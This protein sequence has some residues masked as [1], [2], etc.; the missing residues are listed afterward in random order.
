VD[1]TEELSVSAGGA[2][3]RK[4]AVKDAIEELESLLRRHKPHHSSYKATPD[5]CGMC[6]FLP[7]NAGMY[8][9]TKP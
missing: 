1:Q 2:G 3:L 4:S 6:L 7:A 5:D 9:L 8:F